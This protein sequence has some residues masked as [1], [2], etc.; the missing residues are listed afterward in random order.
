MILHHLGNALRGIRRSPVT[1]VV[2]VASIALGIAVSVTLI[3]FYH[4]MRAEPVPHKSAQVFRVLLDNWQA[5]KPFAEPDLAPPAL[6]LRDATH[7]RQAGLAQNEVALYHAQTFVALPG[8]A[9]ERRIKASTR[10]TTR[11]FFGLFEPPFRYG[12]GWDQGAEG[13]L[14]RVA[15][16]GKTLNDRLFGGADSVG[17]EIEVNSATFRIVGVLD[18]WDLYPLFYDMTRED[19]VSD[20]LFVPFPV[21]VDSLKLWPSFSAQPGEPAGDDFDTRFAGS[22]AVFV[23]Y[24]V[25]LA[26][27]QVREAYQSH[28]NGYIA[29]Q[30]RLG[31]FPR[32][33]KAELLAIPQWIERQQENG[34][35]RV[36]VQ[37]LVVVGLLFFGIC[38]LNIVTLLISR[39]MG[40]AGAVSVLRALGVPRWAIFVD[41]ITEAGLLGLA[42]GLIGLALARVGVALIGPLFLG[43]SDDGIGGSA[44][45]DFGGL[46]DASMIATAIGL[47]LLG[48]FLVALYP[49]WKICRIAPTQYLKSL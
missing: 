21:A 33:A 17:R 38:L 15:V 32:A 14:E 46:L 9:G 49:T 40:N 37:T 22:E 29:E 25:Q 45:G 3:A 1:S 12:S 44:A 7:L 31:R 18:Q 34:N 35:Q 28:L 13:N 8:S 19:L 16:I 41:H 11:G 39:F 20:E 26:T 5:E 2:V 27:P 6:T 24:W 23:Q 10:A 47:S 43:A 4:G 48:A 42:G 36:F 30:K